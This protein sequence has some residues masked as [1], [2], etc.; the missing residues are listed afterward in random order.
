MHQLRN[1]EHPDVT[2]KSDPATSV[3]ALVAAMRE[4]DARI[5]RL[6]DALDRQSNINSKLM[7]ALL[8]ARAAPAVQ[9]PLPVV[10]VSPASTGPTFGEV[11]TWYL[12][13]LSGVDWKNKAVSTMR[14]VLAWFAPSV[15]LRRFIAE[16]DV[17][18]AVVIRAPHDRT[19]VAT[20]GPDMSLGAMRV[21][22]WTE[23]RSW[24]AR[25]APEMGVTSRN[26][27]HGR[28][29]AMLNK[30]VA[31]QFIDGH[32][33]AGVKR[34]P[35]KAKR[36]T[37]VTDDYLDRLRAH[38]SALVWAYAVTICDSGQRPGEARVLRWTQVD[39]AIRHLDGE[40]ETYEIALAAKDTKGK[41]KS[42]PAYL[43]RRCLDAYA[44]LPRMP[45]NVYVFGSPKEPGKPYSKL[46]L[47]RL[48]RDA[49]DAAGLEAAD[50]DG[51]VHAHDGRRSFAS[52]L[53]SADVSMAKIQGLLG[54]ANIATTMLYVDVPRDDLREAHSRLA[55][56]ARLP[57]QR[58]SDPTDDEP[59]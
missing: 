4:K 25:V 34:E 54:H 40:T 11:W 18:P 6:M 32:Q 10:A 41:K 3:E 56:A 48:F 5:D 26:H 59:T 36:Q 21:F 7:E 27:M 45:D 47:W 23:F 50:G 49:A 1:L 55:T 15:C 17:S 52:K 42:R 19:K 24:I 2:A 16:P 28:T 39:N 8:E 29:M 33:L 53:I 46:H 43:T 14:W 44:A 58:A 31:D 35:R 30:A 38:A 37:R 22:H 12:S 57:P 20:A 51:T 9:L 13:S